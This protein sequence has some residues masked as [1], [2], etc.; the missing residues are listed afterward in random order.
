MNTIYIGNLP[1][2]VQRSELE[3][4]FTQYGEIEDVVII[5]DKN[6]GLGKGF[7]FITF[8]DNSAAQAALAEDG[9]EF[10]SR[11]IKVNIAKPR[12]K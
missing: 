7:G 9:K 4:R 12:E 5:K 2:R 1:Y 11:E 8:A 10:G 3:E 6:T